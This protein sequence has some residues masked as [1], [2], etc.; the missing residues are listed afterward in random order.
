MTAF[1]FLHIPKT[2]GQTVHFRLARAL[3]EAAVSPVRTHTEAAPEAQFPPGYRLYSGHLDWVA[4]SSVP[5]PRFVFT[6]LRDPR[7][8]LA[9]FYF[10]LQQ[11]AR[12]LSPEAL[13]QRGD[14]RNILDLSADDYFFGG[15]A[16]RQAFVRDH[17]DN[18]YC[19]YFATRRVRGRG[20]LAGV[21]AA[22]E[23]ARARAGLA[24]I[25]AVY[26]SEALHVLD[27]DFARR[28]GLALGC[29]RRVSNQGPLPQGAPRWPALLERFETDAAR[30]RIEAFVHRDEALLAALPAP[31]PPSFWRQI[32]DRIVR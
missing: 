8:R 10:Y 11:T 22:E 27:A 30:R 23:L 26:R 24:A 12:Q 21:P 19:S 25:D 1:V 6:L 13:Q 2:A 18:F 7:E 16:A 5:P 9:S 32:W 31:E 3:G 28:F 20:L 17:Y 15:D 4:L 14:L 29:A